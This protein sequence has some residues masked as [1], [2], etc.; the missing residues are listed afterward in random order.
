ME[1]TT[2]RSSRQP[3]AKTKKENIQVIVRCRPM[4][5]KEVSNGYTGVVKISKEENSVAVS[6][7]KNDG[8]EYKQFT[9][10]SVFDWNS[11]QEELYKKMV[12]PLIES[13]LNGFNATIFA[14][15]QTGTGKTFTMEGIR[16]EKLP[17]SEQENRGIIPRTFEQIFQTI[18]QSNNKQYLVFSS[19]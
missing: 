4:S 16:D 15:G 9:F 6:V 1:A 3:S 17:L 12:H 14:Y 8:S 19:Y 13:V 18:E 7:P 11:T 2:K 10:D 5:S